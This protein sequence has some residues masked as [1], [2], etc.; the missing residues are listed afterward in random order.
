MRLNEKSS[1]ICTFDTPFGRYQ[2]LRLPFRISSAP[3]LYHRVI[4]TI[5]AH[6]DGVDKSMEDIIIW[7]SD[8]EE[9][10][11]KLEKVL[12]TAKRVGRK[13]QR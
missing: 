5:F 11:K 12:E 4:H 9:H 10:D 7:D 2:Y 8:K 6:I 13:L 3:E 1:E